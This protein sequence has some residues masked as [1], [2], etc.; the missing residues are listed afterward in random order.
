M[1][2]DAVETG[3]LGV[4]CAAHELRDDARNLVDLQRPRRDDLRLS[5]RGEDFAVRRDRGRRD[6]Q[7]ATVKI[8]MRHAPDMPELRKDRPADAMNRVGDLLPSRDLL[9]RMNSGRTDI[10][11]ALRATCVPSVTISPAD[12]R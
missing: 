12:A 1:Q 11:V 9:G 10:T 3:R 6:R 2:F 7:F 5:A 8:G 4:F